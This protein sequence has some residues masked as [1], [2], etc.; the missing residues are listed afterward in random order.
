VCPSCWS[1]VHR[2]DL[3]EHD[4]WHERVHSD[5]VAEAFRRLTSSV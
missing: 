1:V 5:A 4:A 3:G 2:D